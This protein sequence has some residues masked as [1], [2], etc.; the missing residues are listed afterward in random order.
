MNS[1]SFI[2]DH[3]MYGF[4]CGVSGNFSSRYLS[5]NHVRLWHNHGV[6]RDNGARTVNWWTA[7]ALSVVISPWHATRCDDLA[8]RTGSVWVPTAGLVLL[9]W[10]E[11]YECK[12]KMRHLGSGCI[13]N[14]EH[15][16][17]ASLTSL[18]TKSLSQCTWNKTSIFLQIA[19]KLV[20][21]S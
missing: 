15:Y 11:R 9:L 13:G 18:S 10:K 8:C 16:T 21:L 14:G 19:Q 17:P 7:Q 4:I 12:E 3:Y 1:I 6:A 5:I 2:V 20:S